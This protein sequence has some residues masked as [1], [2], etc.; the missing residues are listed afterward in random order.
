MVKW[1][2][3]FV[4]RSLALFFLSFTLAITRSCTCPGEDHPGPSN[5]VGRGAPEIDVLEAEKNKQGSGQVVSQSAQFAPFTHDYIYLNS[6][7]DEWTV[8]NPSISV[9]NPYKG[10]AVQQAVSGLT[11]TPADMF[12]GSGQT[13]TTMGKHNFP[14]C[15]LCC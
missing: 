13:F 15:L 10:S 5:N 8:Y 9:P 1:P 12:Q 4:S 14:F 7:A 11:A 3:P 2:T 6:T